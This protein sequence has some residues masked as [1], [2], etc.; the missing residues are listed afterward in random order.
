VNSRRG[1]DGAGAGGAGGSADGPGSY[2]RSD[3]GANEAGLWLGLSSGTSMDAIDA[4]LVSFSGHG[5][6]RL[7]AFRETPYDGALRSRLR[8]ALGSVTPRELG[9]LDVALGEAFAAAAVAL[10]EAAGR[11]AST[12]RAIG[13][14]GQTL[15]HRPPREPGER[16]SS[17]QVGSPSVVAERTGIATVGDFR[18]RDMAAGG[19]GAPLVPLLD[20]R[21]Y[22]H[23]RRPPVSTR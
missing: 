5:I 17:L 22:T 19:Q 1:P 4:A 15:A 13:S 14:H 16:G 23:P 11:E 6:P 12:V 7:E 3:G 21:L 8:N 10:L 9:D 20:H 18:A 2:H